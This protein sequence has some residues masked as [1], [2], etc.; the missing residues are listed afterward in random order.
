LTFKQKG[1]MAEAAKQETGPRYSKELPAD[2]TYLAQAWKLLEVYSKIP[3]SEIDAHVAKIVSDAGIGKQL[4]R[5][6]RN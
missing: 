4:P 1:N 6:P 2:R 3:A 5:L